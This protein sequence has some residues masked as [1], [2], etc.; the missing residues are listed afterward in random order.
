MSVELNCRNKIK[1]PKICGDE[2]DTQKYGDKNI[3]FNNN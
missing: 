3:Q 1:I 2:I